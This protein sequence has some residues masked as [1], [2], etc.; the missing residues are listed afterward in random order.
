MENRP[1]DERIKTQFDALLQKFKIFHIF[2]H[3]APDPDALAAALGIKRII[4]ACVPD[5]QDIRMFGDAVERPQNKTMVTVLNIIYQDVGDALEIYKK[6]SD[7]VHSAC[8]I[9]VDCNGKSGNSDYGIIPDWIIDHHIDKTI[10]DF[11]ANVDLRPCGACSSILYDYFKTYSVMLSH[12]VPTDA[13]L[14]TALVMGIMADTDSVKRETMSEAD[15]D[16]LK[17]FQPI[18]DKDKLNQIV[19]YEVPASYFELW[20]VACDNHK[21]VGSLLVINLGYVS[22]AT[23]GGIS[24]IADMWEPYRGID[25]ILVY[26]ICGKSIV[27]SCR[28][29]A[30]GPV[31]A[32]DL[33]RGIFKVE[34]GKAG[35]H[36]EMA[37]GEVE[38]KWL[39]PIQLKEENKQKLLDVIMDFVVAEACEIT[40]TK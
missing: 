11:E 5:V 36:K 29:K 12:D 4:Q 40:D 31:K 22:S 28:V 18:S 23:R 9:F 24:Y 6:N 10:S 3:K 39:N 15:W 13:S 1:M 19:K 7:A 21:I 8:K 26:G 17:Y 33:V 2:M 25:T 30:G 14:A 27:V 34:N 20:K 32:N 16:A 37:G 35:G 38:L